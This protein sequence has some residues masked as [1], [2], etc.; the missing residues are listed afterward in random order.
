MKIVTRTKST[1]SSSTFLPLD[2]SY[3][4][5]TEHRMGLIGRDDLANKVGKSEKSN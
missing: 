5:S 2:N 1:D 4:F 3:W